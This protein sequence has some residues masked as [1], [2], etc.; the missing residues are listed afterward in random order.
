MLSALG[1]FL[2]KWKVWR[3]TVRKHISPSHKPPSLSASLPPAGGWT[4]T[5]LNAVHHPAGTDVTTGLTVRLSGESGTGGCHGDAG[6]WREQAAHSGWHGTSCSVPSRS[7]SGVICVS[8]R[9]VQP[10]ELNRS[11]CWGLTLQG[12]FKL[13]VC[14]CVCVYKGNY[15][16]KQSTSC[17]FLRG[18]LQIRLNTRA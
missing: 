18:F 2:K 3:E 5:A 14:V 13:G 1:L 6:R 11:G 10:I 17:S 12:G 4:I 7:L 8:V 16:L 15:A 9:S